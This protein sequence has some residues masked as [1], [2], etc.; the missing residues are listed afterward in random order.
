MEWFHSKVCNIVKLQELLV[1]G[2]I[3][4]PKLSDEKQFDQG[5]KFSGGIIRSWRLTSFPL[6]SLA[7]HWNSSRSTGASRF[8][9]VAVYEKRELVRGIVSCC[10]GWILLLSEMKEALRGCE[11]RIKRPFGQDMVS[12]CQMRWITGNSDWAERS[13]RHLHFQNPSS[14]RLLAGG[15]VGQA[16]AEKEHD[17]WYCAVFLAISRDHWWWERSLAPSPWSVWARSPTGY[18]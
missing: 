10:T 16:M 3:T 13:P 6:S 17:S 4:M 8:L 18:S 5:M 11:G 1:W 9:A 2:H 14:S 7:M 12:R 15:Y